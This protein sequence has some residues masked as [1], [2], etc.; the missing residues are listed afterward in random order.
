MP[1]EQMIKERLRK[2]KELESLGINP[3]P[4][5][6]DQKNH[7]QDILDKYSH[8]KKDESTNDKVSVAGRIMQL[9]RMGKVSFAHLQ[10]QSGK[11]QLYFRQDDIGKEQYRILKLSDIGDIVGASGTVFRTKMGETS[12]Y[13]KKFEIL[14]KS[15]K[16]LPEKWHGLKDK[17]ERYRKRYLDLIMS[18][19]VRDVFHKRTKIIESVR[20]YMKKKDFIEVETP[21]LQG[22]Y[23]GA[24]AEPFVTKLNALDM[25]LFLA[26][27]PELYLKRL[28]VGGFEKVYTI[29]R[30]FRNEGIDKWH[31]PEFT[32]MEIYIAYADYNIMM[33]MFEEIYAYAAKA[34]NGT[35]KVEFKGTTVDFKTPW[36][37][38][39]MA[40]LIKKDAKIDV[41]KMDDKQVLDF[42]I[43]NGVE[44]KGKTWGWVVQGIFEHFC[45]A[46]IEQPTHVIDH[47]KETTPLCKKHRS[48]STGRLI[49][50]FEPFCV[51]TELGNCYSELNDPILQR[52]LLKEQQK[53]LN[54]GI[55]EAN[56]LDEDFINAIEVGLPPTGGL[57]LGIDR[58]IMLLTNQES[59][60]DVIFFP[61]MRS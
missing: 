49:E 46:K 8:L 52:K 34:V 7:A 57:G 47:P 21:Y 17:E 10:D 32:M 29:S 20:E 40:D 2:I 41:L 5:S 14:S 61:F 50:R 1:E 18:K 48:D 27:S 3:Y 30:N 26:I 9:R 22:I 33:T 13:V 11:I 4:Y 23:G 60:R 51:G 45:E 53:A 59:I 16:S 12:V 42:A 15:I 56:P 39:T 35:T 58:M 6:F 55:K 31:N 43:A 19:D 38:V 28:V 24:N 37:R 36:K 25:P 54:R 44:F